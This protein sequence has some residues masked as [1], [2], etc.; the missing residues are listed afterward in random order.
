[1]APLLARLPLV[2]FVGKEPLP[3]S[4]RLGPAVEAPS[5]RTPTG[6][7]KPAVPSS[8]RLAPSLDCRPVMCNTGA[9][10]AVED[11]AL[12]VPRPSPG[13][14][15]SINTGGTS[16]RL[17]RADSRPGFAIVGTPDKGE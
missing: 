9:L 13:L 17:C 14:Q 11:A 2:S 1:M 3:L 12:V 7:E 4:K 10:A 15:A 6:V 16:R 5:S 8:R